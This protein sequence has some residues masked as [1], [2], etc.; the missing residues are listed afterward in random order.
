MIFESTPPRGGLNGASDA[1]PANWEQPAAGNNSQLRRSLAPPSRISGGA[2]PATSS[3]S[4]DAAASPG[5]DGSPYETNSIKFADYFQQEAAGQGGALRQQQQQSQAYSVS[6]SQPPSN[7][8]LRQTSSVVF[9]SHGS[10]SAHQAA[11]L[12]GHSLSSPFY[13]DQNQLR[14]HNYHNSTSGV[15]READF[16]NPTTTNRVAAA[17]PPLAAV[18]SSMSFDSNSYSNHTNNTSFI[19]APQSSVAASPRSAGQQLLLQRS[20]AANTSFTASS[21]LRQLT[22][23]QDSTTFTPQQ[24][25]QRDA[26]R[27]IATELKDRQAQ[28]VQRELACQR[29]EE[30]LLKREKQLEESLLRMQHEQTAAVEAAQRKAVEV[31]PK[32]EALDKALHSADDYRQQLR[33][34]HKELSSRELEVDTLAQELSA[35]REKVAAHK[36]ELETRAAHLVAEEDDMNLDF[37]RHAERIQASSRLLGDRTREVERKEKELERIKFEWDLKDAD[38]KRRFNDVQTREA[39]VEGKARDVQRVLDS[40]RSL[41]L[42]AVQTQRIADR[43]RARE[44]ALW[45]TAAKVVPHGARA[46]AAIREDLRAHHQKLEDLGSQLPSVIKASAV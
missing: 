28:V 40:S 20:S 31:D 34:L 19:P 29:R 22:Q 26:L 16:I 46:V 27:Q 17:V 35:E 43:L 7:A 36:L 11:P 33:N 18:P 45:T 21:P 9:D 5:D 10:R 37:K 30:L 14:S 44:D 42:H 32:Q 4:P 2:S 38:V 12:D 25:A 8:F 41:E 39:V 1:S 15:P 6:S 24:T 23:Q 3:M 13:Q